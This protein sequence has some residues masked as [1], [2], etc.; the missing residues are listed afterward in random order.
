MKTLRNIMVLSLFG[1]PLTVFAQSI[2]EALSEA[3]SSVAEIQDISMNLGSL[4]AQ[5]QNSGDQVLLQCISTKQA[6]VEALSDIS[7]VALSNIS[8]AMN[9]DKALYELRKI[10]LALSKVKQFGNEAEKCSMSSMSGEASDGST[11]VTVDTTR[12]I[13]TFDSDASVSGEST[14]SFDS[15]STSTDAAVDG[16][17]ADSV[18]PPPTTSPF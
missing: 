5:A 18:F 4:Y 6:S 8:S 1:M 12:V 9:T 16:A 3:Q 13:N 17:G 14:Y 2:S 7:D 15:T 10:S 11:E